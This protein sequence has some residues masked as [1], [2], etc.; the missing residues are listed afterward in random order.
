MHARIRPVLVGSVAAVTI[1]AFA[2]T[3]VAAAAPAPGGLPARFLRN[4]VQYCGVICP[5]V[6]QGATTVPV[7]IGTAPLTFAD[8][9]LSESPT[10]AAGAA[11]ASI[12]APARAA[13][14]P[15]INNDLSLVLP[16][17]Q[18]ALEVSAVEL[19]NVG[20]ATGDPRTLVQ[21]IGSARTN[22]A[23][24]LDQPVGAPVGPTGAV[25]LPQVVAVEAINVGSAVAFQA[26]ESGLR[27]AVDTADDSAQTL[28]RTGNVA[29]AATV[30]A[31]DTVK[32]VSAAGRTV[33]D[34][35]TTAAS[36]IRN[37]LR[38]PFPRSALRS[39][40]IST[41]AVAVPAAR[42]VVQQTVHRAI[43][44]GDTAKSGN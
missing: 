16:K 9:L 3:A 27:D 42:G 38:D 25:N 24:A 5:F 15:I 39:P 2:A 11:V 30:G 23:A 36:H 6:V 14:D 20:V 35:V 18:N 37:S 41:T 19:V 34:S 22:I 29:A 31:R 44:A 43:S 1:N 40:R 17:A 28:A 8:A 10:Q 13:T 26:T 32:A 12:T 21:A 33:T 7:A 4:Q